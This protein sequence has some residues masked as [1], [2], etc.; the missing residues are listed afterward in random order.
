MTK[1]FRVLFAD[2]YRNDDLLVGVRNRTAAA[3]NSTLVIVWWG[4]CYLLRIMQISI[5]LHY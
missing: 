1:A 5:I 4:L 2:N 3:F